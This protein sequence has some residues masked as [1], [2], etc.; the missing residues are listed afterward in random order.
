MIIDEAPPPP[1]QMPA[2]PYW[3]G[4]RLCTMW[5]TILA[6]DIL[7]G[8]EE[9]VH[10]K[11]SEVR[12]VFCHSSS[13]QRMNSVVI[14]VL[15]S[16]EVSHALSPNGVSQGHGSAVHINFWGVDVQHL[17][18]GQHHHAEGLVDLPHGDVVLLQ[19]CCLQSLTTKHISVVISEHNV[20]VAHLQRRGK[21][22][23]KLLLTGH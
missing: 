3:P 11:V 16:G 8:G 6:P 17:D 23:F 13:S 21:R 5:P 9:T 10:T 15:L 2:S 7:T 1:L 22:S 18:V 4:F 20:Y 14:V 12:S 19:A